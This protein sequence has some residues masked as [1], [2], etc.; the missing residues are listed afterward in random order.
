MHVDLALSG[1]AS[2]WPYCIHEYPSEYLVSL[3]A[4]MGSNKRGG[5]RSGY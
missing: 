3:P 1:I 2:T 4:I 5:D